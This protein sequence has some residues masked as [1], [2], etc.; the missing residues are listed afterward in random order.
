MR[1]AIGIDLGKNGAIVI[2]D[3]EKNDIQTM[4]MPLVGNQFDM[5]LMSDILDE[6]AGEDAM[7]G[8]EDLRA[9]YGASASATFTFGFI[10]GATE[11][12]IAAHKIPY[13]K[14]NAKVWQREAFKGIPEIRKPSKIDKNGKKRK[15]PIDTKAMA[16]IAA[17]RLFPNVDLRKS[18]RAKKNHDG[19]IDALLISWYI[20]QNYK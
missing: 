19:I 8:I 12:L 4:V 13:R 5:H 6:F 20:E 2:R 11:A 9:I 7:V 3:L 14:I 17:K 18:P 15:G 16:E 10:C 1:Y